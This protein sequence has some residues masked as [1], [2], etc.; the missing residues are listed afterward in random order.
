METTTEASIR[1]RI[2]QRGWGRFTN[3]L[4]VACGLGWMADSMNIAALSLVLP[5]LTVEMA[6]SRGQAGLLASG[7]YVGFMVGAVLTGKLADLFGRRT[8][9]V[10]NIIL[11]SAAS[12][13]AGFSP[14]Y[15]YLLV[16]RFIQGLGLGAEFPIIGIYLNEMSPKKLLNR[17]VGLTTAFFAYG[18]A[19]TP[20]IGLFVVPHLGWRG[21]FWVLLLPIVLTIWV[22]RSLPESPVFLARKGRHVE[23]EAA[24]KQIE[25]ETPQTDDAGTS[26][27]D[28]EGP[29]LRVPLVLALIGLWILTFFAQYGFV[30]WVPTVVKQQ[31]GGSS[32]ALTALLFSGMVVG[33]LLGGFAGTRLSIRMFVCLSFIEFGISLVLFGFASSV[34]PMVLFGWFAA[35]GYGF[36][37]VSTYVYTPRQFATDV[38]GTGVGL[39][40][41]V[42]RIGA[43]IGP[44]IAGWLTPTGS[45]G[46]SFLVFGIASFV[47]VALVFVCDRLRVHALAVAS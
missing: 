41:G 31:T 37:T 38:R 2:D 39:V 36:T 12:L 22:R 16:I 14:N 45:L 1:R 7:T 10:S 32:Y 9:L 18:F 27:S 11:F 13:L 23:A 17:T 35:A 42:G 33:Y 20:L 28:I 15:E 44:P 24:I 34:V 29:P 26:A 8:L 43:I 5:L 47:T 25:A 46:L 40:T 6:I 21:L 19:L 3:R 30:T 4:W